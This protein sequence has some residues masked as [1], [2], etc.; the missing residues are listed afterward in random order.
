[1]AASMAAASPGGRSTCIVIPVFND[2]ES[3][4]LLLGAID[5][6][7]TKSQRTASVLV[8]DDA[9]T[10]P[11]P[12]LGGGAGDF[13]S[14]D[15]VSILRLRRNLGHQRAIAIGLAWIAAKRR[16]DAVCVMD[17]DGEDAPEDVPRLLQRLEAEHGRAVVFAQR[18]RRAEGLQFKIFYQLYR[19]AHRVLTG[20]GIRFGNFSAISYDR[21][22]QLVAASELWNHYA[23]AVVKTRLPFVTEPTMRRERLRGRSKMNFVALVTHGLSAISV[24]SEVVGTRLLVL[25]LASMALCAGLLLGVV[26]VKLFT[27]WAIPGWATYTAV[28]LASLMVQIA[29]ASFLFTFFVLSFRN[30]LGFVPARDYEL[31]VQD[32][33]SLAADERAACST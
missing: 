33:R 17:G 14:L 10:L 28:A 11:P 32:V 21:V 19:A 5:D 12:A 23:A 26:G 24:F 2:W 22:Y 6:A 13:R 16:C 29:S 20:Q 27:P 25:S 4:E 8:V 3:L 30:N 1:M 15:D 7:L 18:T 31:F 9:S